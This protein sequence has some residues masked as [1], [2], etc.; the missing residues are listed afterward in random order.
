MKKGKM[1]KAKYQTQ[2]A[3]IL[4]IHKLFTVCVFCVCRQWI[5]VRVSNALQHLRSRIAR[6]MFKKAYTFTML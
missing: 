6:K 1:A 5:V 2:L 3:K 4:I